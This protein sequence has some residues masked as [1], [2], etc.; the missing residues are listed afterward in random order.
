MIA[1]ASHFYT[2]SKQIFKNESHNG[3]EII[4]SNSELKVKKVFY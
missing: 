1:S 2:Y 3:A 4:L